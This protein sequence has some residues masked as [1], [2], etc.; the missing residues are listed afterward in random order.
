MPSM[1]KAARGYDSWAELTA[2]T[3]LPLVQNPLLDAGKYDEDVS[4]RRYNTVQSE[5]AAGEKTEVVASDADLCG[6]G[7]PHRARRTAGQ[8]VSA[9]W[10][11][12]G[13]I[14]G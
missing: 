4:V 7:H 8:G 11:A 5:S 1:Q 6:G 9:F 12:A 2:A 14:P 13:R 10:Q 3:D